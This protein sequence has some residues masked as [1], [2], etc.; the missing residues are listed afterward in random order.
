MLDL[1]LSTDRELHEYP[2]CFRQQG[3]AAEKMEIELYIL[4]PRPWVL[5]HIDGGAG[6]MH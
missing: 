3:F 4:K 5:S 2:R 1:G 6:Q